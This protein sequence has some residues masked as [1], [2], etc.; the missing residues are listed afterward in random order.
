MLNKGISIII[1]C[2]N[3]ATRLPKTIQHLA[4][5]Q[6]NSSLSVEVIIVDNASTDDTSIK[7]TIELVKYNLE[8]K[9]IKEPKPGLNNA[10]KKG[11]IIAKNKWLLFC[12]DDN[13][14]DK[15]YILNFIQNLHAYP[16]LKVIGCGISE[17]VYEQQPA[18]WF[19]NYKH[20]CAI[21]DLNN[22]NK[23]VNISKS[24]KDTC[25]VCGAGIFIDKSALMA[26][27]EEENLILFGRTGNDLMSGEDVDILKF[28]IKKKHEVGQFTNLQLKHYIP[29]HR[30][31]RNY[32]LRLSRAMTF[33]SEILVFKS[34]N[35]II[36]PNILTLFKISIR[37]IWELNW[38]E[39]IK[40]YYDFRGRIDAF[41]YLK[42]IK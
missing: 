33:S 16:N 38:F 35:L 6:L 28:M 34:K 8:Y 3:S 26:Y 40:A 5:L 18:K 4:E 21:F 22:E 2:Y 1:C 11:A 13:W 29:K 30:I 27:F 14:L 36:K 37:R 32:I 19:Y 7:A 9:I 17:A 20:L 39:T 10:R 31:S 24:E 23:Q 25:W 15:N 42:N 41:K 12:D